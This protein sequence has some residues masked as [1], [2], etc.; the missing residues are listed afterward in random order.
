L[1]RFTAIVFL[2]VLLFNLY[3]YQLVIDYLQQ[4]HDVKLTAQFDKDE[5]DNNDLISIKT[6]LSLPYYS[7]TTAFER[8]DGAIEI[9]GVEYKYV[10]RRIIN[11]SLELLCVPNTEKVKLQTAKS[12]FFKISNDL[13][14]PEN[15]KKS[16]NIIKSA[17]PEFCNALTAYNLPSLAAEKQKHVVSLTH[18]TSLLFTR[19]PEQPP[20]AMPVLS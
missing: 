10:K 19:T 8:V 3:G 11:D 7:N 4:R 16:V 9:N 13:Q 18:L 17:L 20:D 2:A 1:K 5:Y 14:R 15:G 6:P 12:D